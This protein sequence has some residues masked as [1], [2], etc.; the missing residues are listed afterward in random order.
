M[1]DPTF[2]RRTAE[3]LPA[4]NTRLATFDRTKVGL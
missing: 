1:Q 3:G 4:G 2:L